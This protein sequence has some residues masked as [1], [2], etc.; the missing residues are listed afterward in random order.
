MLN[1][2]P[3]TDIQCQMLRVGRSRAVVKTAGKGHSK[4]YMQEAFSYLECLEN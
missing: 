2:A 4:L 3:E 1:V